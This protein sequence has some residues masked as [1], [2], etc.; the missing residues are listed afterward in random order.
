MECSSGNLDS[1]GVTKESNFTVDRVI[2]FRPRRLGS[3]SGRLARG[4]RQS[5]PKGPRPISP[6][7]SAQHV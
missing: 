3:E 7:L 2:T 4:M 5:G 6:S 1:V